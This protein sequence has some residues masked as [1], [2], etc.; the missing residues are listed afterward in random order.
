MNLDYKPS[1]P[2]PSIAMDTSKNDMVIDSND[3]IEAVQKLLEDYY[4]AKIYH[5]HP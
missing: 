3:E 4:Y 1:T 5:N 2:D